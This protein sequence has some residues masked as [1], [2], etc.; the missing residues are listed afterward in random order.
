M[1]H[2]NRTFVNW[3]VVLSSFLLMSPT[4]VFAKQIKPFEDPKVKPIIEQV[5]LSLSSMEQ[6]EREVL[7]RALSDILQQAEE[8]EKKAKILDL[9][10]DTVKEKKYIDSIDPSVM[11]AMIKET[12]EKDLL[13]A[14]INIPKETLSE[15]PYAGDKNTV[16]SFQNISIAALTIDWAKW[17]N[18]DI[19]LGSSPKSGGLNTVAYGTYRHAATYDATKG[20]FI[21]AAPNMRVYWES[22]AFWED[23]YNKVVGLT[24]YYRMFQWSNH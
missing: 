7:E 1:H 13:K 9:L 20:S 16:T 10:E 4:Q 11:A 21:S 18:G 14:K 22:K 5:G 24:V 19:I 8:K 2:S 17:G 12:E 15:D 3:Y 6:K 23:S